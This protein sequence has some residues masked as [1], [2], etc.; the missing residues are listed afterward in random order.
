M[1]FVDFVIAHAKMSSKPHKKVKLDDKLSFFHQLATLVTS[2]T[3]LLQALQIGSEQNQSTRMRQV[4][5]DIVG[6]VASG[7]SLHGSAAV[8]PDLFEHHWVEVIK[9]GEV[10]GKM[11]TVLLGRVDKFEGF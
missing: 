7:N 6:R 11:G 2:G 8:Y 10:T 4:L 1:G 9:T 5:E 3:P